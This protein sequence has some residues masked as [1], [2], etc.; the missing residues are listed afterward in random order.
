MRAEGTPVSCLCCWWWCA[1]APRRGAVACAALGVRQP[2]FLLHQ[3]PVEGP[4]VPAWRLLALWSAAS[5]CG[6]LPKRAAAGVDW[7]WDCE[8]NA[9]GRSSG[10]SGRG[11]ASMSLAGRLPG[12]RAE[13]TRYAGPASVRAPG[14]GPSAQRGLATPA[15]SGWYSGMAAS[16]WRTW[17]NEAGC[18]GAGGCCCCTGCCCCC[19]WFVAAWSRRSESARQMAMAKGEDKNFTHQ[20][21]FRVC[22]NTCFCVIIIGSFTC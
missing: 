22:L 5:S 15:V 16:V 18:L 6:W 20:I 1:A 19:C 14:C 12:L 4:P 7:I 13:A 8:R 17:G 10:A 3:G 21:P 11:V 9:P 2:T